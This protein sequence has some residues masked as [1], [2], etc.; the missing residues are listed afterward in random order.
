MSLGARIKRRREELWL[1]Q[2][3]L[4][5]TIGVS[6]QHVS[7]WERDVVTPSLENIKRLA[8][9]LQCDLASLIG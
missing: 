9:A 4:G 3:E 6:R 1:T 2:A 5:E 8:K 7:F